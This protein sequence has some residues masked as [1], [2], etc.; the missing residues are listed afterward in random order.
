MDAADW[1][2]RYLDHP[3]LWTDTANRFLTET[4]AD[5]T[6]GTALDLACGEGRNALWLA[7]R[8]W[9]VTGLDFSPVAIDRAREV[10]TREQLSATFDTVDLRHWNPTETFDLVC[11]LYLH[12]NRD[13]MAPIVSRASAAVGR[14]GTLFAIGHHSDNL[15]DGTGGPQAEELLYTEEEL[16]RWCPLDAVRAERV[17]RETADGGRAID[18]IL[19][20]RRTH[21]PRGE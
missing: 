17:I 14:G 3:S 1:D 5:L 7:R 4:V 8:G 10:A 2:R 15:V 13:V 6:P 19:V 12:L 18:A 21:E 11:L 16:V 20:A 9:D